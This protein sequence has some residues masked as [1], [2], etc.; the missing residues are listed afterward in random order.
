MNLGRLILLLILSLLAIAAYPYI[1]SCAWVV[2]SSVYICCVLGAV[3]CLRLR[4]LCLYLFLV[5]Q[6][7][8][9]FVCGCTWVVRFSV[10]VCYVFRSISLSTSASA[11]SILVPGFLASVL[12]LWCHLE[13]KLLSLV[14]WLLVFLSSLSLVS[15]LKVSYIGYKVTSPVIALVFDCSYYLSSLLYNFF[16]FLL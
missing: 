10:Y 9:C 8:C 16:L 12:Y 15:L 5:Y 4:L 14:P 6:L 13:S 1:C 3:L 2:Y 11:L 7:L